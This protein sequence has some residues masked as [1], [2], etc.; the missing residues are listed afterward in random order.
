MTD[1]TLESTSKTARAGD[2][3]LRYHEAGSGEAVIMLHGGGPGAGGWSNFARNI[4]PFCEHY[5]TILPDCPGFGKSDTI[6]SS[7][8]RDLINA[9]AV[10]DLMD[11]LGIEKA[12]LVGNSMG[13]AS[14]IRFAL[15]YPERLDRLILMGAG[16]GGQSLFSPQPLEGIKLLFRVYRDPTLENLKQMLSVFVYDQSQMTE[17]LIQTR[18]DTMMATREHLENFVKSAANP[19]A[20]LTDFTPRLH[21]I[22]ARTLILWGRDDRFVPL[23]HGLK[24]LWGIPDARLHVFSR[25]GHWCQWEH[26]DEF[27]RLVMDFIEH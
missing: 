23:D 3:T 4:G 2:L 1:L 13:G 10:R 5:R 19:A 8:P 18:F 7:E 27:N 17:E 26:A 9:R 11:T 21:E 14:S 20:V 12:H 16:G 22:Q 6:V 25:C 24:F 15:E